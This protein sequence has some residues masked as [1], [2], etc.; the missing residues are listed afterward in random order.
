MTPVSPSL[1]RSH[2]ASDDTAL[3]DWI[4]DTAPYGRAVIFE[5]SAHCPP[6]EETQNFVQVLADFA[7]SKKVGA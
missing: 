4:T 6:I 2:C 1:N 7:R 5:E 3:A